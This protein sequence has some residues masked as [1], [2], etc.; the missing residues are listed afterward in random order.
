MDYETPSILSSYYVHD[1]MS[2]AS[3][4]ASGEAADGG[5]SPTDNPA[6]DCYFDGI[7]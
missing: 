2:R 4:F 1:L 6:D 7:P 3:G 5:C